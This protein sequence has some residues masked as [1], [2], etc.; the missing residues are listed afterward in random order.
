MSHDATPMTTKPKPTIQLRDYQQDAI[1]AALNHFRHSRDSAV[2]VLPTGAGKSLVIA[3]L[4]RIA[5]G[6]VLVLTHVKELVAQNAE[7]VAL[8]AGEGSIYSAGLGEK[9]SSGKTVIAGIQS[10]ARN[11]QAF[12]EPFSLVIIDECH[13]VSLDSNSQYHSLFAALKANNPKLLLLGLTATP[14]RLGEGYIYKRHIHGHVGNPDKAVFDVCIYDLPMRVLIK[15]GFLTPPRLLDGLAAQYNFDSL[16]PKDDADY[17]EAEV[18]TVLNQSGRAT[19]AIVEQLAGLASAKRG[20]IIFAATVRHAKEVLKLLE[21]KSAEPPL[22]AALITADTPADERDRIIDDFKAERLQF[23][24]NVSVLT[25]GFDAP[26]VDLIAILRPTASV[27]LFQQM[28]GRGLRLFPGKSE[29]LILD[30]AANGFSLFHP[31]VGKPRP[32]SKSVPVQ[33]PCPACGFANL[34]WGKTDADGDIIEHYGRRC[35]GLLEDG[36]QCDFRYRARICPDCGIENDI[37]ARIC[38]GCDSA[39][40]D[41]DKH[42][43]AVLSHKHHH[44]FKVADMLLEASDEGLTIIYQDMDGNSFNERFKLATDGQRKALFAAFLL[45][46]QRAPGIKLPKYKDAAAIVADKDK[47]RAPDMLLLKKTKFG[48]QLIDKFFDYRGKYQTGARFAL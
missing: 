46:H 8:L 6:R 43:K 23:L 7:K 37:A 5:K 34:F 12:S 19:T 16:I 29:C 45:R 36:N 39:L 28:V 26:H 48:W 14:Y 3:E 22:T 11:P 44:L 47:F 30:Y 21:K 35:Q 25:T 1:D 18:N 2:L 42:L 4:A 24:V 40:V 13:R 31:E 15:K 20:I 9:D 27:S 10:A 32:D 33:V 38:R 41:P 17:S